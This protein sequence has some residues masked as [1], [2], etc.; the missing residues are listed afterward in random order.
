MM[1]FPNLVGLLVFSPLVVKKK[2]REYLKEHK[3]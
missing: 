2:T 3:I 1:A